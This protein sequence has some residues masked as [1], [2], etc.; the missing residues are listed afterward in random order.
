LRV[1]VPEAL[2]P[3]RPLLLRALPLAVASAI[4][5]SLTAA[6][7]ARGGLRLVIVRSWKSPA[8]R[9]VAERC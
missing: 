2:R 6:C 7:S 1:G 5:V 8:S 3:P 4:K 9:R